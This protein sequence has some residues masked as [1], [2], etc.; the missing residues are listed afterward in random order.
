MMDAEEARTK[1][2][3][4]LEDEFCCADICMAWRWIGPR[5]TDGYQNRFPKHYTQDERDKFKHTDEI[6]KFKHTEGYCGLAGKP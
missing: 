4:M 1:A 2:C 6:D 5:E 3:H